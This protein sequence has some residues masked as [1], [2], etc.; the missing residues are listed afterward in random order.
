MKFL[1]LLLLN[2]YISTLLYYFTNVISLSFS[3]I[4]FFPWSYCRPVMEVARV[5]R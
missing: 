3:I 4:L 1:T 5:A 2:Q